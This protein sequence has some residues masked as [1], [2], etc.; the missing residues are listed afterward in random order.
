MFPEN[1]CPSDKHQALAH[2]QGVSLDSEFPKFRDFHTAKGSLYADW[3]AALRTWIR[4]ARDYGARYAPRGVTTTTGPIL[5]TR[6]QRMMQAAE[7]VV[8]RI[9]D[10]KAQ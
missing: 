10:A 2:E 9:E 3:D 5:S 4:N 7:N 8:R 1:F 6:T